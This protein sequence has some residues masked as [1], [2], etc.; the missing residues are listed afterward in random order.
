MKVG[1][2]P[3]SFQTSRD[4]DDDLK[5]Y[6]WILQ[7]FAPPAP[8]PILHRSQVP[9][10]RK[11]SS[12]LTPPSEGRDMGGQFGQLLHTTEPQ[13]AVKRLEAPPP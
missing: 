8:P 12:L 3:P 1:N 6:F 9:P 5:K 13:L 4:K 10:T 2:L 11:I 7:F